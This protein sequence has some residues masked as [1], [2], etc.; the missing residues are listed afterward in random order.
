[1]GTNWKRILSLPQNDVLGLDIGSSMVRL[2]Q[3]AKNNGS[4]NVVAAA[5]KD[6]EYSEDDMDSRETSAAEAVKKC[7]KLVATHCRYAVCSVS[8][9][10]VAV[11][12]FSFPALQPEELE[13]A[14]RLE[15]SQVCPFNVDDGVVDYQV[16]E[17]SDQDNT[18][19]GVLVAA[20][21]EIV[22]RKLRIVKKTG[23]S[24]VLM[25]VDGLALLNCLAAGRNDDAIYSTAV[26]DLGASCAMLAIMG[27]NR[28]PFVRT[29]PY[30]GNE[31]VSKIAD[32]IGLTPEDVKKQ[33]FNTADA[34]TPDEQLEKSF[35]NTC[36]KLISYVAESLRY[37]SAQQK[38]SRVGEILVCGSFGMA[39]GF[40][41]ILNKHL[42]LKATLWN[43]FD[44]MHCNVGRNYL[45]VIQA[46]GPTM[47]V[48]AGLAMRSI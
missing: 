31:I 33:L 38:S 48:A 25:D 41:D 42:P 28:L 20:P 3:L 13:G 4:Y 9:P 47:V 6:I 35:E 34:S 2:V 18:A 40:I 32:E 37:H 12:H 46:K 24:C 29:V 45:N 5:V 7:I 8:G 11:R 15:A 17:K 26:L 44:T 10:E 23:L 14:V 16:A 30:G 39:R 1:M 21:G 27:E 22:A 19:T 43:P 36:H